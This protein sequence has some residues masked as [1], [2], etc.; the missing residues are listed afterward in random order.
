MRIFYHSF[1]F[2]LSLSRSTSVSFQCYANEIWP[3]RSYLQDRSERVQLRQDMK[4]LRKE[5][6]ER[7][8]KSTEDI[9]NT[10]QVVLCTLTGAASR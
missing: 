3:W 4:R 7:E 6:S 5:L 10:A 2:F 9:L 8:T 1:Y